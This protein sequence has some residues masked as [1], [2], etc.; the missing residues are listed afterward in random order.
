MYSTSTP[1]VEARHLCARERGAGGVEHAL[2]F[3]PRGAPVRR[4]TRAQQVG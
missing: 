4:V 3:A 2:G 1:S